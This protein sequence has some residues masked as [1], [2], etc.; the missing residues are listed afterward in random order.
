VPTHASARAFLESVAKR[1]LKHSGRRRGT[2][3]LARRAV[4]AIMVS[5]VDSI[6]V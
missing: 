6:E 4:A 1:A 5:C 2:G 3:L